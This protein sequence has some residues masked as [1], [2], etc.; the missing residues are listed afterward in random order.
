MVIVVDKILV[1]RVVR[2][3]DVNH[4]DASGMGVSQRGEGFEVV[5][6]DEDMVGRVLVL[7]DE[8]ALLY[9]LQ[10]GQFF[11]HL[12]L[13]RFGLVLPYEAITFAFAKQSQQGA[14]L[15]VGQPLQFADAVYQV[16]SV[17]VVHTVF[18]YGC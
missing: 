2:R 6:L 16:Y 1:A 5:A 10:Y 8:G 11:L 4:V 13:H 3:I 18:C 17:V 14:A 7:A 15:P 12:V 9:F